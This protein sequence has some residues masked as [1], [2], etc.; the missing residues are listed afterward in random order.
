MFQINRLAKS[1]PI[2][3]RMSKRNAGGYFKKNIFVEE[4]AGMKV[5]KDSFHYS[6]F[7]PLQLIYFYEGLREISYKT[8]EF[9][10]GSLGS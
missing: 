10:A 8:W 6:F 2:F 9:D 5:F 1:A 7:F 3:T 4:N